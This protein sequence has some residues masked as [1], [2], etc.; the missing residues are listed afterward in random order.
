MR[1]R[2]GRRRESRGRRGRKS[3]GRRGEEE[4]GRSEQH[5]KEEGRI[6]LPVMPSRA[7]S[8]GQN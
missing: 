2:G 7:E 8:R 6:Y 1:T 4:Q 5:R 3:R